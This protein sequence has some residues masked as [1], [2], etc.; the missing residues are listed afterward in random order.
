MK[1]FN[2]W[3]FDEP[4]RA[5]MILFGI[6]IV[7]I[8]IGVWFGRKRL[9]VAV[10]LALFV[11]LL[12]LINIPSMIPAHDTARRAMCINNLKLIENAK[13]QWARERHKLPTDV[14][15]ELDLCGTNDFLTRMVV[16]PAGG[17]YTFGAVNENPTCSLTN[18]GHKLE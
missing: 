2:D 15:T 7:C 1:D 9:K 4:D 13:S 6:L 17:K 16:C 18:K 3:V 14:P 5:S 12:G 11:L 8:S 10:P